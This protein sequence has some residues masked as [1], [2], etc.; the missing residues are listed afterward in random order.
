MRDPQPLYQASALGIPEGNFSD[1]MYAIKC[2]EYLRSY[3]DEAKWMELYELTGDT[4]F[5]GP[6][7]LD[8]QKLRF[9]DRPHPPKRKSCDDDDDEPAAKRQKTIDDTERPYNTSYNAIDAHEGLQMRENGD[10]LQDIIVAWIKL[11]AQRKLPFVQVVCDL[12]YSYNVVLCSKPPLS[13]PV[14]SDFHLKSC[15]PQLWT[16]ENIIKYL[17]RFPEGRHMRD[18]ADARLI[19]RDAERGRIDATKAETLRKLQRHIIDM[20][21]K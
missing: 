17:S 2:K 11:K 9:V 7:I 12:Y 4:L 16:I 1:E 5:L 20:E 18:V 21:G 13:E 3:V 14:Y 8:E 19:F 15:R 6:P 10:T